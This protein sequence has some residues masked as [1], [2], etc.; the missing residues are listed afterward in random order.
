M[1]KK[2]LF[3]EVDIYDIYGNNY[4]KLSLLKKVEILKID[5]AWE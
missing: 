1:L 2:R 3:K 5:L 4:I